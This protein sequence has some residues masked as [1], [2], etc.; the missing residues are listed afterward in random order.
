MLP[1]VQ[2]RDGDNFD[3]LR[4]IGRMILAE[5]PDV[6]VQIGDF[7]DVPS[8]GVHDRGKLSFE[9]R[10]YKKDI[11]AAHQAMEALLGPIREYNLMRRR[12]KKSIYRPRMV[13]TLGN[14]EG[15]ISRMVN[16]N[17]MLDGT[18]SIDDLRYE[19]YGWEVIPF[20]QVEVI[21]GVA[22]AHYFQ[23]GAMGRPAGS[24]QAQLAKKH[25]SMVAG[26][27]QGLSTAEAWRADGKRMVSI[28]CGSCYQHAENYLGPQGNKHWHGVVMLR[29]VED[30]VFDPD[31]VP[32]HRILRDYA[33]E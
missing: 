10:R 21:S 22:F 8:C 1:D 11:E 7:A 9:G 26:H 4:C 27:Q 2:A 32:L 12:N 6:V 25:M 5:R 18:I 16:E 17:S 20:L 24:A 33:A 13:L 29:D 30:G 19:F 15:R 3:F 23:T 31:Y 28:I 14:H